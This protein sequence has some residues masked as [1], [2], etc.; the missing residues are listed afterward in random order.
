MKLV[1]S[2]LLCG[3][4]IGLGLV[5]SGMADPAKVL[6]FLDLLGQWDPTLAFV[7]GGGLCVYLPLYHL[8]VKPRQAPV[9]ALSFQLPSKTKTE[10]RLIM[11]AAT[12]GIG[13]GMSGICPGPAM[14]N[15][16][17]GQTGIFLFVIAMLV[18]MILTNKVS[19]LVTNK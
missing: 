19:D 3:L 10:K 14:T 18:G 13:W 9:L 7:M 4:L 15:L 17:G 5:T 6:G 8:I 16:S 12:F 2:A 1:L 11:G